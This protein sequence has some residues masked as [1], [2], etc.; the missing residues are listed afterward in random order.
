MK[1]RNYNSLPPL[2]PLTSRK[3]KENEGTMTGGREEGREK[4]KLR[5]QEEKLLEIDTLY[6]SFSLSVDSSLMQSAIKQSPDT[7]FRI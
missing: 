2:D 4:E 6:F 7:C 1:G 5:S 3:G